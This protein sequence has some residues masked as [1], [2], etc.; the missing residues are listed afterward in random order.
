MTGDYMFVSSFVT[1]LIASYN[2]WRDYSTN[3]RTIS[4]NDKKP[5]EY[6]CDNIHMNIINRFV[7]NYWLHNINK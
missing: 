2:L 6:I 1:I 4:L 5:W 3:G 7:T